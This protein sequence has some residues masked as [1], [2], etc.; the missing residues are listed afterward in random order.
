V[1]A[2]LVNKNAEKRALK[3]TE[4]YAWWLSYNH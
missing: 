2:L 3:L 1:S 4:Q